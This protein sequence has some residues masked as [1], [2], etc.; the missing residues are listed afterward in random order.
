MQMSW[1]RLISGSVSLVSAAGR[2]EAG[3]SWGATGRGSPLAAP[4]PPV[5]YGLHEYVI[6]TPRKN[7]RTVLLT[8]HASAW[9]CL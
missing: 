4:K 6:C 5:R 1:K 7:L 3:S 9:R 8:A 2:A